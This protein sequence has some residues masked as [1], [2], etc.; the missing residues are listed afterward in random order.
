MQPRLPRR[1]P[2]RVPPVA[3]HAP[4]GTLEL[5]LA[6]LEHVAHERAGARLQ[7]EL[8]GREAQVHPRSLRHAR[9]R[10]PATSRASGRAS[11]DQ[12]VEVDDHGEPREA[13][14]SGDRSS[15]TPSRR[16][17]GAS[18]GGSRRASRRRFARGSMPH[19]QRPVAS[20]A[21]ESSRQVRE[22]VCGGPLEHGRVARA[23]PEPTRTSTSPT[24]RDI[25]S[26]LARARWRRRSG[27]LTSASGPLRL[28][29]VDQ[30]VAV[31]RDPPMRRSAGAIDP[32]SFSLTRMGLRFI[33]KAADIGHRIGLVP[34]LA[35]RE[36]P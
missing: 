8:R 36:A 9:Q 23:A 7:L 1:R 34:A 22:R 17:N 29:Q 3:R 11:G 27:R 25:A 16:L 2:D 31:Q 30:D 13:T 21:D 14:A 6:R 4:A 24:S 26:D 28:E 10:P 19:P 35:R 15:R 33:S 18:R 32:E 20:S 12:V 5:D